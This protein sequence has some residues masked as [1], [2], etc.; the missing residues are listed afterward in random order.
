MSKANIYLSG[1]M[2]FAADGQLGAEWRIRCTRTLEEL[3]YTAIDI[4]ALDVGYT[5]EYGDLFRC[6]PVS[7]DN[8]TINDYLQRKAN[9]RQHFV[10]ADLLLIER[11]TDAMIVKYCNGTRRGAG[12]ISECQHAYNRGIPI[13]LVNTFQDDAEIPGWLFALTTRIFNTFEELYDYLGSLP[14][15]ILKLDQYQNRRSGNHYLCSLCGGVE[16]KH[17]AH[18]VSKVTPL[19]CKSCVE[20]VKTTNESHKNRYDFFIEEMGREHG[21]S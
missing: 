18:F 17:K 20:L 4:T 12:T 2:E 19:Y 5:A 3:G 14:D 9:I 8:V 21:H 1:A 11:H 10:Q 16:E 15:G 7:G 13:F 6:A